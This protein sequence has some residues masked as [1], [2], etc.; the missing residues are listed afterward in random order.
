MVEKEK[1]EGGGRK[2]RRGRYINGTGDD[3][4]AINLPAGTR[5]VLASIVRFGSIVDDEREGGQR[6]KA[7]TVGSQVR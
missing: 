7:T 5:G 4:N 6:T 2:K 1:A 3:Q